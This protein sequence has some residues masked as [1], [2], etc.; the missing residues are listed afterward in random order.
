MYKISILL[1][2][3]ENFSPT[4]PGAVSLFVNSTSQNH[5]INLIASGSEV[6]IALEAQ[7]KLKD[8]EIDSKVVSMPCQELFDQQSDAYK[9]EIIDKNMPIITIEA[10]SIS[11][12]EKYSNHNMGIK[13]FGES[14]PY[15]EVYSHFNLTSTKVVELAKKIIKQ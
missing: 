12:W 9:N 3:K 6:E 5:K 15:K 14:A 4:Y 7:K 1:P 8:M 13:T 2:Y 11:S 10:S